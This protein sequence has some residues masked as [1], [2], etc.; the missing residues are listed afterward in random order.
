MDVTVTAVF[1][2]TAVS[3]VA[4]AVGAGVGVGVAVGSGV[5]VG[6]GVGVVVAVFPDTA[7]LSTT[8]TSVA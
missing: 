7:E 2:W 8:I 3:A 4:P 5:G 1:D 6:V